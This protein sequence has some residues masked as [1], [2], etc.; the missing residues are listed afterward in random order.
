MKRIERTQDVKI[1][2]VDDESLMREIIINAL[3]AGGYR[4]IRSVFRL[5]QLK[6]AMES[7]NPDLVIINGE[8]SHGDPVELVRQTRLFR[9]GRNP[10]VPVIMTSWNSE[11]AFVQ[12]VADG[13]IDVLMMKPFAAGQLLAR[14]DFL[15]NQRP[16][17]V[18]TATYVGP[19]RRKAKRGGDRHRFDAPNTLRDRIQGKAAN[20]AEIDALITG[21][22]S[23]I[24]RHRKQMQESD[25]RRLFAAFRV[26]GHDHFPRFFRHDR[27]R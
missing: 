23:K 2:L 24:K 15:V 20:P 14:I 25:I 9:I 11:G 6:S 27:H 17:F 18:A 12:R 1:L 21:V 19:D 22:F 4:E 16:H 7:I 13:G 8:M 26:I 3:T 5:E 10:F